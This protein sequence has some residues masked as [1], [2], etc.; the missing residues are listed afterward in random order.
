MEDD[1]MQLPTTDLQPTL[2]EVRA[3]FTAWRKNRKR[4]RRIPEELWSAAVKLAKVHTLN[5]ISR[6]LKLSYTELKKRTAC[7]DQQSRPTPSPG[8]IAIDLPGANPP[9]ECVLEMAHHNGNKMRMHFKGNV[10][11]DLQSLAEAFWSGTCCR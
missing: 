10:A 4:G 7:I 3:R 9:A 5:T 8:F 6:Q 11:L 1:T 2:P